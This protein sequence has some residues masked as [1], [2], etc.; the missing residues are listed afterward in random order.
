MTTHEFDSQARNALALRQMDPDRVPSEWYKEAWRRIGKGRSDAYIS[1]AF[2]KMKRSTTRNMVVLLDEAQ[3][4]AEM[5][6]EESFDSGNVC[7]KCKGSRYTQVRILKRYT[8]T[9]LGS[10]KMI[11]PAFVDASVPC[12]C[13]GGP[14]FDRK[15]YRDKAFDFETMSLIDEDKK[16]GIIYRSTLFSEEELAEHMASNQHFDP[17][18][19]LSIISEVGFDIKTGKRVDGDLPPL[20]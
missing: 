10:Q 8:M 18:K 19:L 15:R 14:V 6:R 1:A 9:S 4:A 11:T 17:S 13:S 5:V 20:D 2:Y 12:E 7:Q 16:V 3:A